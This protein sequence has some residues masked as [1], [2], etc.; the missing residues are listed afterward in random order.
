M[1]RRTYLVLVVALAASVITVAL[2]WAGD[3]E[4]AHN[5][6]LVQRVFDEVWNK[7]NFE[8]L[9]ELFAPGFVRHF[10]GAP[11]LQGLDAFRE[12]AVSHRAAFP[13][14]SEE[15]I[16]LVAE[17]DLVAALFRSN[18]TNEGSFL[19]HPPTGKSISISEMTIFRIADGKIA[20]QW[21]IP[22]LLGLNRQLGF[23]VDSKPSK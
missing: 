11:P 12:R 22:D 17:G 23:V 5:K 7:G 9:D 19:G 6:V 20:E 14:W 16:H 15:V 21:L 3:S 2:A 8:I 13:D 1:L 4:E 10:P 18:G